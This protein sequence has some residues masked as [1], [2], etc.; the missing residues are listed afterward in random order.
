M[1]AK[2]YKKITG[3]FFFLLP[4][5]LGAIGIAANYYIIPNT[6]SESVFLARWIFSDDAAEI[7]CKIRMN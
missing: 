7:I 6:F 4:V 2:I 3:K 5:I 1:G